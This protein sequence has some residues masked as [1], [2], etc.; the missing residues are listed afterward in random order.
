M[1]SIYSPSILRGLE[2]NPDDGLFDFESEPD[3]ILHQPPP[4]NPW[5]QDWNEPAGPRHRT[6]PKPGTFFA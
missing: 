1:I 6:R 3:D 4:F 2:V 5:L